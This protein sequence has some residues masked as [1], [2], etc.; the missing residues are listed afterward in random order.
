MKRNVLIIGVVLLL[1]AGCFGKE[2][3]KQKEVRE[4]P[5][6][7]E[8]KESIKKLTVDRASFHFIVDWLTN[9]EILYVEKKE[10]FYLLKSFD[11]LTGETKIIYEEPTII[12][13]VFIHPTRELV[14]LHTT[15]HPS[16]ATVKIISLAGVLQNEVTIQ[17]NEL[18]IEWNDINPE[19]LLL[20]AFHQ[21][22]SF[23]V[24][25]FDGL[26]NNLQLISNEDPFPK[27]LGSE[28]FILTELDT[29]PLDGGKLFLYDRQTGEKI[30]TVEDQ[31]VLY[32]TFK[33]SL[34]HMRINDSGQAEY[35]I[36]DILGVELARWTMPAISNYSEWVM[37]FIQWLA[38]DSVIVNR[39][40]ESGLL[41]EIEEA[42]DIV[43]IEGNEEKVLLN[44]TLNSSIKCTPD[45]K[46]CITGPMLETI[47]DVETDK[48]K[49][50]LLYEY[51]SNI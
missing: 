11:V 51:E 3:E 39:P 9:T 29:H 33:E 44:E 13:D 41:D 2:E 15:D 24:F 7:M 21:D 18:E 12:A 48:G 31:V 27:W 1:L 19:Y 34:L 22:W 23:D 17:S 10:G 46:K 28:H 26:K 20:T 50:W 45:T 16:S 30:D 5:K 38:S 36:V 42:Y 37:P 43:K 4:E 47:I 6:Q 35:T 14:L 32:D 25:L 8:I 40:L 49:K